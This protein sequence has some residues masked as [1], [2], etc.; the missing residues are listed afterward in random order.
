MAQKSTTPLGAEK[1]LLIRFADT[2]YQVQSGNL[3]EGVVTAIITKAVSHPHG[4]K[5][6]LD[7]D[8]VGWVK[9]II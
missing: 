2:V 3:P 1:D 7:N 6:R 4:I 5:V 9:E 8:M